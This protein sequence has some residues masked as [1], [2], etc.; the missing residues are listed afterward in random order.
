MPGREAG[1]RRGRSPGIL[2]AKRRRWLLSPFLCV[3]SSSRFFQHPLLLFE[4]SRQ[5][6]L[7]PFIK[8]A[9]PCLCGDGTVPGRAPLKLAHIPISL[10]HI[11]EISSLSLFRFRAMY[12]LE[13]RVLVL[14][15]AILHSNSA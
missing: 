7:L 12:H 13:T 8:R 3:I 1:G 4:I 15:P 2:G 6:I 14:L 5:H 11:T 9:T 10:G